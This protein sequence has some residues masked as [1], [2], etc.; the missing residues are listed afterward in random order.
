MALVASGCASIPG[1]SFGPYF[2]ARLFQGF[3]MG[4]AANVGLSIV[5]DLSW[6]HER[7]FS[8]GLWALAGNAGLFIGHL[9]LISF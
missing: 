9:G 1:M 8:V 5:I 7:G 4:P 3:G 2:V 6:E